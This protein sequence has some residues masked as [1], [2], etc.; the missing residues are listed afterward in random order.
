MTL[1][2]I[3]SHHHSLPDRDPRRKKRVAIRY[4][5]AGCKT[6]GPSCSKYRTSS[7]DINVGKKKRVKFICF[8]SQTRKPFSFALFPLCIQMSISPA[9]AL[10]SFSNLEKKSS[11]TASNNSSS[12]K[13]SSKQPSIHSNVS[14]NTGDSNSLNE[15]LS[16]VGASS[17]FGDVPSRASVHINYQNVNTDQLAILDD[18]GYVDDDDKGLLGGYSNNNN[19]L[20]Y[21]ISDTALLL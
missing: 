6:L 11:S 21:V 3:P 2:G 14:T 20:Y 7:S 12:S 10:H 16:P 18:L 19:K 15:S 8:S 4:Q 17:T 13:A 5:E 1:C 9:L